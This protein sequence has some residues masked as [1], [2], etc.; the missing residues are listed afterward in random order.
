[1]ERDLHEISNDNGVRVV[2]F[3]TSKILTVK[4]MIFPHRNIRKFTWTSPDGM[5]HNQIDS[6]LIERGRHSSV[7]DVRLFRAA[8]CDTDNY[9]V[10]TKSGKD[11]HE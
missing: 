5:T 3:D 6:I 2:N 1:L 4:S 11:W 9:V 7:L 10:V 8:D